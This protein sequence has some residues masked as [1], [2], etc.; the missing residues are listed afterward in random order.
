[1]APRESQSGMYSHPNRFNISLAKDQPGE[2]RAAA[3]TSRPWLAW[4]EIFRIRTGVSRQAADASPRSPRGPGTEILCDLD[5]MLF[6]DVASLALVAR[7]LPFNHRILARDIPKCLADS[8]APTTD[9]S[10]FNVK[11]CRR[12]PHLGSKG[13]TRCIVPVLSQIS[14]SFI[15]QVWR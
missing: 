4:R 15:L 5:S 12:R 6:S 3:L 2:L 7:V 10:P 11:R 1:M 8:Y 13:V 9:S 14:T